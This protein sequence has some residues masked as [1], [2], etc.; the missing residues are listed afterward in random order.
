VREGARHIFEYAR[1]AQDFLQQ[2][3][4]RGHLVK[5]DP[6]T[7]VVRVYDPATNTFGAYNPDGTTRTFYKPDPAKHGLPTNLDYWHSQPGT[8]VPGGLPPGL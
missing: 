5:V 6:N 8:S 2:A 1:M 4:A 3:R 7:G